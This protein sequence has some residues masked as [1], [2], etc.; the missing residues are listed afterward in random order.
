MRP[1][2]IFLFLIISF[3]NF[4]VCA[5][6]TASETKQPDGTLSQGLDYKK[7]TT[8]NH[9]IHITPVRDKDCMNIQ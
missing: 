4:L 1:F 5:A 9:V 3:N 8:E 2:K 6:N 7:T